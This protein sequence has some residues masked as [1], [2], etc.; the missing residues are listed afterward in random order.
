[1]QFLRLPHGSS[2]VCFCRFLMSAVTQPTA[3]S[4]WLAC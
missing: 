4:V 3:A 2:F 1:L